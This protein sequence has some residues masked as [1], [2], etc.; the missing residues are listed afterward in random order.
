MCDASYVERKIL[1]EKDKIDINIFEISYNF[2]HLKK[3]LTVIT[4]FNKVLIIEHYPPVP[5]GK[6]ALAFLIQKDLKSITFSNY[7]I[8]PTDYYKFFKEQCNFDESYLILNGISQTSLEQYFDIPVPHYTICTYLSSNLWYGI[9]NEVKSLSL[10]QCYYFLTD[11]ISS[12][13]DLYHYFSC[14]SKCLPNLEYLEVS[15]ETQNQ[16]L[17]FPFVKEKWNPLPWKEVYENM[18]KF[19]SNE[20]ENVFSPKINGSLNFCVYESAENFNEAIKELGE[21]FEV[22]MDNDKK[23]LIKKFHIYDG[24]SFEFVLQFDE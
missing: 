13:K 11:S 17:E 9:F 8:L 16:I 10:Q 20:F 12:P 23:Q 14:I 21:T 19:N 2:W 22:D 5:K 15:F 1:K 6:Q 4:K 7:N 24:L 3:F 18:I